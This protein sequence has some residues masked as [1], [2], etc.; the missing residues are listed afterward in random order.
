MHRFDVTFSF[1][2]L[3]FLLP[4]YACN[5]GGRFELKIAQENRGAQ[6]A[7]PDTVF[8]ASGR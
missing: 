5:V 2:F 7:L 3:F 1:F 4:S 8:G 6:L